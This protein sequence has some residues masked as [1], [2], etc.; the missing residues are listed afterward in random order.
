MVGNCFVNQ[1]PPI[2][3]LRPRENSP[4]LKEE[5]ILGDIQ[6]LGRKG[7]WCEVGADEKE[8]SGLHP[9]YVTF[10]SSNALPGGFSEALM[11]G[12]Y[13]RLL[14]STPRTLER[15]YLDAAYSIQGDL[16]HG[17]IRSG[18]GRT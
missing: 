14:G 13:V 10:I 16:N 17:N 18:A 9:L 2:S 12:V 4:G 1:I 11:C 6:M 8:R 5:V 7:R 3:S 15:P